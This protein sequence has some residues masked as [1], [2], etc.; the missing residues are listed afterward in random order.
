MMRPRVLFTAAHGM[1]VRYLMAGLLAHLHQRGFDVTV[2]ASPGPD[3]DAVAGSA[4]FRVVAVRI[5]REIEPLR[6]PVSLLA[7]LRLM[8]RI[9]PH[10]VVA[11]TPKAGLLGMLAAW[12]TRV[13]V[14]IYHLRGLRAETAGGLKRSLLDAAERCTAGFSHEVISVSRSLAGVYARG[15]YAP[16]EKIRVLGAGSSNGVR[17]ERFAR[18]DRTS[19]DRL[20]EELDLPYGAFVIGFVGRFTRDKG[21]AELLD[22]FEH[23]RGVEPRARLLMVGEFET[24]D[25]VSVDVARRLE[26]HDAIRRVGFVPDVAPYL[27]IMDV[28]AFPSR[29]EGF[30]NVPLEAAAAGIPVVGF[31]AT[32]VVDAVVNG[33]TGC[34]VEMGDSQALAHALL[35]YAREPDLRLRHGTAALERVR[36][37]FR[38][39]AIWDAMGD[40][41]ERLLRDRL[42]P[43]TR[44]LS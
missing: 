40:E 36:T 39:E 4:S 41:I 7:L 28:M 29:R 43:G 27:A 6:D 12:L 21:I 44:G 33:V 5:E 11:A 18:P 13:P 8:R 25:P 14:R 31:R 42:K 30:P 10:V 34:L 23:V 1:T 35:G 24:G 17:A 32:G 37:E 38:P 16:P 15:G 9:R 22:A 26:E 20:R 19:E 2:A 3:L